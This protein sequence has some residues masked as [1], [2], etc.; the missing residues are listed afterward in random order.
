[1]SQDAKA[2]AE[3]KTPTTPNID[4]KEALERQK[5]AEFQRTQSQAA[6]QAQAP[7]SPIEAH[8]QTT[9]RYNRARTTLA[10]NL[11]TVN[12]FLL[13]DATVKTSN[14]RQTL[15]LQERQIEIVRNEFA[16]TQKNRNL[17]THESYAKYRASV[18]NYLND[19]TTNLGDIE[20]A[21]DRGEISKTQLKSYVK[22]LEKAAVTLPFIKV[23]RTVTTKTVPVSKAISQQEEL[24]PLGKISQTYENQFK[25]IADLI[26][27]SITQSKAKSASFAAEG[28]TVQAVVT[29]AVSTAGSATR[30]GFNAITFPVR[31]VQW[32]KTANTISTLL[33]PVKGESQSDYEER[34]NQFVEGDIKDPAEKERVIKEILKTIPTP[35]GE[36]SVEQR[37]TASL[38]RAKIAE[39]IISDPVAFIAEVAGG[40]AGGYLAGKI[41][42][43]LPARIKG[44]TPKSLEQRAFDKLRPLEEGVSPGLDITAHPLDD[45]SDSAVSQLEDAV[46]MTV[47]KS[48]G[49]GKWGNANRHWGFSD[50]MTASLV[51]LVDPTTK[52]IKGII[53]MAEALEITHVMP[54]LLTT[55]GGLQAIPVIKIDERAS[56][57]QI[58]R[59]NALLKISPQATIPQSVLKELQ[60]DDLL[61]ETLLAQGIIVLPELNQNV[62]SDQSI[63][64]I[65]EQVQIQEQALIVP[66]EP[67]PV[68]EE[69]ILIPP[70]VRLL[71]K[72]RRKLNLRL[73]KGK[74]RRYR[75]QHRYTDGTKTTVTVQA[76]SHPEAVAKA[77]GNRNRGKRL[78]EAISEEA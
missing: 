71:S 26:T 70:P 45:L 35:I 67:I 68:L 77:E 20:Q 15:R 75:V 10:S 72:K 31:P 49:K 5:L 61:L 41:I 39:V 66:I 74:K 23:T 4:T 3:S 24:S 6:Q 48:L 51:V 38:Y 44:L 46:G 13:S 12:K 9:Q 47:H 7:T 8:R 57:T 27:R 16:E 50:P 56:Q 34:I 76:Q 21:I 19:A 30:G 37:E 29:A 32:K 1:M 78:K 73:F 17:Y 2:E 40:L 69:P 52:A 14:A 33:T 59:I 58:D 53:T 65:S 43:E 62:I 28:K 64:Q 55:M 54:E 36:P 11:A 18:N 25:K 42:Q 22:R 60:E 63:V